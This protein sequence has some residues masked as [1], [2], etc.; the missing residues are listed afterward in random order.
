[1]LLSGAPLF[2][3]IAVT[4]VLSLA[5][6]DSGGGFEHLVQLLWTGTEAV[7][8]NDALMG[9]M[10]RVAQVPLE[11]FDKSTALPVMIAIPLFTLAGTIITEGVLASRLINLIKTIVGFLPGGLALASLVGCAFFAALSGSSVVTIMAIG[12]ALYPAMVKEGYGE[13]FS[14]GLITSAGALGILAPPGL[15]LIIF[16]AV[17]QTDIG[18]LF[19]AGVVPM[20]LSMVCLSIYVLGYAAVKGNAIQRQPFSLPE[21]LGAIKG[22]FWALLFPIFLLVVIYGGF[23]TP[24]E[25]SALAV[26]Y[27]VI[28]E[29]LI[30]KKLKWSDLPRLTVQTMVLVGGILMILV[31][32]LAYT[33]YLA[34]QSV[35]EMLTETIQKYITTPMGFLIAVNVL[36]LVVGAMMDILSAILI[37]APLLVPMA[38]AYGID[39]VH[40]GII[41]VINLEIGFLTPPFGISLFVSGNFFRRSSAE[42]IMSSVPFVAMLFIA[43]AL[44][45]VFP[46][47]SLWLVELSGAR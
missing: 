7:E 9:V 13:R 17:T 27:A 42:V 33:Y 30:Y 8:A 14:L 39:L 12:G 38:Q 10:T 16:G 32:A 43:L 2:L 46:E 23:A 24:T 15:P 28:V 29:V 22:G 44:I 18:Q 21:M 20:L 5:L 26:I 3:C 37:V 11:I 47:L 31:M 1:M 4:T 41:F 6:I 19:I 35:P 36:L 34:D 45:T 25:A 40:L